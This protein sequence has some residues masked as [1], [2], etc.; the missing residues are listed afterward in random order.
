MINIDESSLIEKVNINGQ[1]GSILLFTLIALVAMTLATLALV[2]S[3]DSTTLISG[4]LAFRQ[5]ATSSGDIDIQRVVVAMDVAS[6][7]GN[8]AVAPLSIFN[9]TAHPFNRDYN[10]GTNATAPLGYYSNINPALNLSLDAT[11][12]NGV[13][14]AEFDAGNGNRSRYIIQRMCR[15]ANQLPTIQ[16]CLFSG[17]AKDSDDKTIKLATDVC[18]GAGCPA[19]GQSPQYRVTVR[20]V[21]PKNTVSFIQSIVY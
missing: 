18:D 17:A 21:G 15:T 1:R 8:A 4:N 11:W 14:S 3:V 20:V 7:A 6:I 9:S 5:A 2:R 16:N 12:A 13:A 19:A 10:A